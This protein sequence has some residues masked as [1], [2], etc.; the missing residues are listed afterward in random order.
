MGRG[1]GGG[2]R[3]TPCRPPSAPRSGRPSHPSLPR[4]SAKTGSPRSRERILESGDPVPCQPAD[5]ASRRADRGRPRKWLKGR[6]RSRLIRIPTLRSWHG[7][8]AG[9]VQS[10]RH[11][12]AGSG[13]LAP[14]VWTSSVFRRWSWGVASTGRSGRHRWPAQPAR[15]VRWHQRSGGPA[16]RPAQSP[17]VLGSPLDPRCSPWS[18]VSGWRRQG[19]PL[20]ESPNSAC[21]VDYLSVF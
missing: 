2:R 19:N 1:P 15:R 18:A 16:M 6:R 21:W 8:G 12:R 13:R 5:R 9:G 7:C 17:N 4:H 11:Q 3:R 10:V 20:A 14:T